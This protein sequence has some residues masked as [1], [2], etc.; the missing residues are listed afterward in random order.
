MSV[1]LWRYTEECDGG[2]CVGD[3]DL[4][5]KNN[6]DK[7]EMKHTE[8]FISLDDCIEVLLFQ[9][10]IEKEQ[11]DMVRMELEQKVFISDSQYDIGY[12]KAIRDMRNKLRELCNV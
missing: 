2:Y 6:E 11:A 12:T 4:C 10:I 3:C 8:D 5:E 1:S 9:E 7:D